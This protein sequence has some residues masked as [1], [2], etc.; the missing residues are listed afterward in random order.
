VPKKNLS[1]FYGLLVLREMGEREREK[2]KEERKR[3]E[4]RNFSCLDAR[5]NGK[6]DQILVG[7]HQ[8]FN[9]TLA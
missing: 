2:R 5:E 3:R 4:I 7:V 9:S 1:Q 6:R 8:L